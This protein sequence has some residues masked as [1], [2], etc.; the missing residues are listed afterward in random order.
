MKELNK[1]FDETDEIADE[2]DKLIFNGN[3]LIGRIS[4]EVTS[5]NIVDL[6]TKHGLPLIFHLEFYEG[7]LNIVPEDLPSFLIL[8]GIIFDAQEDDTDIIVSAN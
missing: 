8:R 5:K 2:L 3:K 4:L 6:F 7:I 1:L